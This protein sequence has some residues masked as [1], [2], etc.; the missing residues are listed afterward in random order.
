MKT[1]GTYSCARCGKLFQREAAIVRHWQ[2][3][4]AAGPFCSLSCSASRPKPVASLE[5]RFWPK[6]K[7]SNGCWEWTGWRNWAG[8]GYLGA[9]RG[10]GKLLGAHRVSYELNIGPIPHGL[11]VMHR[12][13]NPPCVRPDHLEL[14]TRSDNMS[15]AGRKGRLSSRPQNVRGRPRKD[16]GDQAAAM[17]QLDEVLAG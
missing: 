16:A 8:Y 2:R 11:H 5:D 17:R 12:C 15:D 10:R 9:V 7:K 13:D 14:G 1:M 6:V 3:R 4:G